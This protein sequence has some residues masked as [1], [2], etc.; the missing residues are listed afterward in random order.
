MARKK[1]APELPKNH[2]VL[3]EEKGRKH[4]DYRPSPIYASILEAKAI[5]RDRYE[6]RGFPV[7]RVHRYD[8]DWFSVSF[9]LGCGPG[10]LDSVLCNWPYINGLP[11]DEAAQNFLRKDVVDILKENTK[12]KKCTKRITRKL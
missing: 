4:K 8:N 7:L 9:E 12:G 2:Q 3:A 6:K 1:K 10:H 5:L 11:T